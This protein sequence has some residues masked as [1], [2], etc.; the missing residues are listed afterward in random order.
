M[1]DEERSAE[2]FGE[3]LAR[4]RRL[5]SIRLEEIASKTRI[6]VKVLEALEADA[7]DSLPPK[8]YVIGFLQAYA[9]HVGLDEN[10]VVLRYEAYTQGM[11][12]TQGEPRRQWRSGRKPLLW[13]VLIL[14]GLALAAVYW[15]LWRP[16]HPTG[17]SESIH[18]PGE[19]HGTASRP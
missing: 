9:R 13:I 3:Y 12:S 4:E 6:N 17:P 19:V 18:G 2:T 10:E 15:L 7:Y 1:D 8:V 14:A 11:D 5:R 16:A